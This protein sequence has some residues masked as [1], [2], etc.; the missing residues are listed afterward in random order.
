VVAAIAADYGRLRE[1]E[2][3][4]STSRLY[5]KAKWA[6]GR[7]RQ[8]AGEDVIGFLSRSA[9]IPKYGFPVDV[10]ELDLQK[11]HA[12]PAAKDVLLQRDL[13]V[14]VAEFAPTCELVANKRVWRSMG[15]KRVPERPLARYSYKMCR[16]HDGFVAWKTDEQ[17]EPALPCGCAMPPAGEFLSPRFGFVG[18]L[19]PKEPVRRP[20]RMFTTRPHFLGLVRPAEAMGRTHGPVRFYPASPGEMAVVCEGRRGLGFF[21][22]VECGAGFSSLARDLAKGHTTPYGGTCTE[23]LARTSLGHVFTTDVLRLDFPQPPFEVEGANGGPWFA[24]SL[25]YALLEGAAECLDVPTT[26]IGVTIQGSTAGGIPGVVLYDNVPGGA[27]LVAR[28]E[29]ATVF[30]KS[31]LAARA[32]VA[33]TCGCGEDT[34]CY[35]CLRSYRNQHVHQHLRRGPVA[36]YLTWLLDEWPEPA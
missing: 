3:Q 36:Q 30:R 5:D 17:V 7:A 12:D 33:G 24:N 18:S 23:R 28:L 19:R 16:Q 6:S 10:V 2:R 21:I 22:C 13:S 11:A 31:V 25:A 20:A 9:I 15:V 8:I 27:G 29:D 1:I 14:A 4:A 32:R 35:G 26:D 34:S